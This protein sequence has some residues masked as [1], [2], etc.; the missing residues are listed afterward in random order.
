VLERRQD[1][2]LPPRDITF[3]HGPLW[4][5]T[6]ARARKQPLTCAHQDH[7]PGVDH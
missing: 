7:R 4:I 5:R 1:R 6:L 3:R 2:T